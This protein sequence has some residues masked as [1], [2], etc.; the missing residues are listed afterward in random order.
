M[1]PSVWVSC[2]P[3]ALSLVGAGVAHKL[4]LW[5][6]NIGEMVQRLGTNSSQ[7]SPVTCFQSLIPQ[8]LRDAVHCLISLQ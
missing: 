8:P 4:S 7:N 1:S 5:T 6:L 3:A 2:S